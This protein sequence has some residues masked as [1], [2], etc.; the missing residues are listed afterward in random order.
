MAGFLEK[1]KKKRDDLA[2]SGAL[3]SKAQIE[4]ENR[5]KGIF[6]RKKKKKKKKKS[7][8]D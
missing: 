7:E 8:S 1:L 4:V 2:R 3:G 5:G 6:S